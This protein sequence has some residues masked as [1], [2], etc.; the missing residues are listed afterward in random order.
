MRKI[1][2]AKVEG[3]HPFS[4][5]LFFRNGRDNGPEE[6]AHTYQQNFFVFIVCFDLFLIPP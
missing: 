2:D 3:I 5:P 1:R 4:E 6:K